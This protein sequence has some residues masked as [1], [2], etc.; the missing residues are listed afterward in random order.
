M[1]N[2]ILFKKI[3]IRV[4]QL[5]KNLK[6]N[7]ADITEKSGLSAPYISDIEKGKRPKMSVAVLVD[8]AKALDVSVSDLL[9]GIEDEAAS[10]EE[11]ANELYYSKM[12]KTCYP[13]QLEYYG[14]STLLQV[15]LY[16]P[17]IR[18]QNLFDALQRIEGYFKG[19]ETY[20]LDQVNWCISQIPASPAKEY[21]DE[22]LRK[23]QSDT[24]YE[25]KADDLV[26]TKKLLKHHKE[27]M[28]QIK[29]MTK[30]IR[31]VKDLQQTTELI[32]SFSNK[33][34]Q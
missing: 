1:E 11:Y 5:R 13:P 6:L 24:H 14:V 33:E 20:V 19:N 22:Y 12:E 8:L 34:K 4:K 26:D 21:A 28:D 3:G 18:P 27:Y 2:E 7:I 31:C 17:L 16:L 9:L 30:L 23:L 25:S 10:D 32:N 15:L 29:Q